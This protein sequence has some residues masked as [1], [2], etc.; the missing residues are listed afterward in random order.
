MK[1]INANK[2]FYV[3]NKK[4][5]YSKLE[6]IVESNKSGRQVH[7]Y[8]YE[9]AFGK[10]DWTTPSNLSI[11]E[12][13]KQRALQLREQYDHLV[14]FYSGG[15]DSGYILKTFI[16][17][18][19]KID[20]IYMFGSFELEKKQ[21]KK[22]GY[23]TDAGYYTREVEYI[24]KPFIQ[25][26]L[27]DRDIKITEYDWT[28]DIVDATNDIDWFWHAGSRFTPDQMVR[29]K[30]HKKFKEHNQLLDKGKKV[31]FISGVDKP[32]LAKDDNSIYFVFLDLTLT[33]GTNNSNDMFGESWE[34]DEFFYW[35]PNFPEIA[36]KQSHML[37]DYLKQN[38]LLQHI[39]YMND[40]KF[41]DPEYYQIANRIVYPNWDHGL[42]Q[43]DK[44]KGATVGH[45]LCDWFYDPSATHYKKWKSSLHE[46]EQQ[47][48]HKH[49][50]NDNVLD[51]LQGHVSKAYTISGI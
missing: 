14:L 7:W 31:G 16:D 20:E 27:K 24:A 37:V 9:D 32:K 26:I 40:H 29:S 42:W 50:N 2:G 48:G 22:L 46:L 8:F 23:S 33:T 41:H 47:L 25:Q 44:P 45:Q 18:D 3:C 36:I 51:G 1:Y 35:T 34:N 28:N 4:H 21:F 39:R 12:L 30:F 49:F 6:A 38:N 17:N 43:I 15:V 5:F 13:Y 11:D 10:Y 19:I